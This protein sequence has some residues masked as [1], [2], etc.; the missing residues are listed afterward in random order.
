M[1]LLIYLP[2]VVVTPDLNASCLIIIIMPI[3]LATTAGQTTGA[4]E[5]ALPY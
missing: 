2:L 1:S 3:Y 4:F 5:K